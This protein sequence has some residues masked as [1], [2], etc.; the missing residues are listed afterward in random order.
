MEAMAF[1]L[2]TGTDCVGTYVKY[3]SKSEPQA[4][5]DLRNRDLG[6][7]DYADADA[8]DLDSRA[9][10]QRF[11]RL[12]Y[13]RLLSDDLLKPYFIEVAGIDIDTHFPRI[14]DYWCKLLFHETGYHRHTMNIHRNINRQRTFTIR[15][16]GRWLFHFHHTID[17]HF[18]GPY[19][20]R[21]KLIATRISENMQLSLSGN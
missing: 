18:Q 6:Q 13:A 8:D 21:A 15:H 10:V 9:Q 20:T 5:G 2:V 14:E 1:S 7:L 12:F 17:R 4:Q 3:R 16:Y 19:A 11:V